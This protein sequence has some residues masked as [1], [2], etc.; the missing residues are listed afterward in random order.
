MIGMIKGLFD[1]QRPAN[2]INIIPQTWKYTQTKKVYKWIRNSI[3][4]T[5]DEMC[6]RRSFVMGLKKRGM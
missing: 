5:N 2:E 6:D 3:C 1:V 4:N